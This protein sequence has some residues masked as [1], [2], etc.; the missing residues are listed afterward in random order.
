MVYW[1]GIRRD[2][3]NSSANDRR[4]LHLFSSGIAGLS[5]DLPDLEMEFRAEENAKLTR[6]FNGYKNGHGQTALQGFGQWLFKK[7]K[8]NGG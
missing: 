8:V 5:C 1:N 6:Q 3:A 7:G 2:E 4:D